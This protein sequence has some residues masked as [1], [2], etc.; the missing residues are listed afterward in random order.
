MTLMPMT[1]KSANDLYNR[2]IRQY[3]MKESWFNEGWHIKNAYLSVGIW[4]FEILRFS[5]LEDSGLE[6]PIYVFTKFI[7]LECSKSFTG[8]TNTGEMVRS[9]EDAHK[10]IDNIIKQL[11]DGYIKHKKECIERDFNDY[12]RCS[13]S[14]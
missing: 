2:L 1:I 13:K 4:D 8:W 11:K 14:N 5:M 6:E 12:Q 10:L 9:E 3:G 7:P